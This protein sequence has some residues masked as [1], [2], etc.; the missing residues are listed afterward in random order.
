MTPASEVPQAGQPPCRAAVYLY[1]QTGQLREVAEA[2]TAPLVARGWDI[3]LVDVQPR[4]GFP[5]PWPIRRFF[6][7]FPASV[8]PAAL[9]H[10]YL[11]PCG[12]KA[13]ADVG[14]VTAPVYLYYGE[15]DTSVPVEHMEQWQAAVQNVARATVYPGEGH[16]AQY[17]H[18]D[19]ILLDMA[20]YPDRTVVCTRGRTRVLPNKQANTLVA[21]GAT[22]G[23]CAWARK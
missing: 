10:E 18:W 20:G 9:A 13:I 6:A 22:L 11:L 8:D 23:N 21:R 14:G 4:V 1:S 2:L 16:T 5:F 19:Q 12:D 17:R 7:V 15:A 3:R